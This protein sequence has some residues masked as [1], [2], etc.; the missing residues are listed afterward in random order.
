MRR[1]SMA[2]AS[3]VPRFEQLLAYADKLLPDH[4]ASQVPRFEQ[5]LADV[6]DTDALHTASQVPRFEQLLA[7]TLLWLT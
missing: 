1:T 4:Q 6:V 3:Q 5:L 7:K 2:I